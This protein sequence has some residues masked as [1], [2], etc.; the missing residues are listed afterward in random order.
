[1]ESKNI[2][3]WIRLGATIRT[4]PEKAKTILGGDREVLENVLSEQSWNLDGE[5]Y[6]PESVAESVCLQLGLDLQ[7][8]RGD[9]DFSF[10][11]DFNIFG[12]IKRD[13]K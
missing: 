1:M 3:I 9:I 2:E 4:S 7:E 11:D 8:Y 5:S 13:K 10:G 6:I 12:K